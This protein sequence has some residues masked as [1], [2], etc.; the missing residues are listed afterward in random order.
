MAQ[1]ER[2]EI[3]QVSI[4]QVSLKSTERDCPRCDA[5]KIHNNNEICNQCLNSGYIDCGDEN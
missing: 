1:A 2:I 4:Q 3:Q 5:V